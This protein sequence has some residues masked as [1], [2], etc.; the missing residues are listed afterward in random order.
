MQRAPGHVFFGDYRAAEQT[1]GAGGA[2]KASGAG[3]AGGAGGAAHAQS[4]MHYR[5]CTAVSDAK[6]RQCSCVGWKF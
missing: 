6:D 5:R 3:G 4:Q 1:V 2:G